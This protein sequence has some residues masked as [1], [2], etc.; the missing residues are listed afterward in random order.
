M[1]GEALQS[2]PVDE[3][4]IDG[5]RTWAL[6]DLETDKIVSAKRPSLWRELLNCQARGVGREVTVTLPDKSEWSVVDPKLETALSELFGRPVKVEL[7]TQTQQGVYASDWPEIEGLSLAGSVDIPVNLAGQGTSFVDV[8]ALHFI[9]TA[10]LAALAELVPETGT[11]LRRFRPSLVI[12]TDTDPGFIE[13]EW[14]G[15][16]LKLGEVQI[17]VGVPTPRCVM[18]TLAQGDLASLPEVL[19]TL[20]SNNRVTSMLGTFASLGSYASVNGAGV[21]NVGDEVTFA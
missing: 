8:A 18:P 14:E 9:T 6:R 5:D 1:Q 3:G 7:A 10:S 17:E 19:R 21:I 12:D 15:R 20:A 13:N 11:D 2:V 4:G 16:T